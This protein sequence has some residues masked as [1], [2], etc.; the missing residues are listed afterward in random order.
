LNGLVEPLVTTLL[1]IE[2]LAFM[3]LQRHVLAQRERAAKQ[4]SL[5]PVNCR[6]SSPT[7]VG[8]NGD[9]F[10]P[11][12]LAKYCVDPAPVIS[13]WR[14]A[15]RPG[16]ELFGRSASPPGGLSIRIGVLKSLIF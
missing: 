10:G 12:T 5:N 16:A 6:Q 15:R 13:S 7:P 11:A 14:E 2:V 1:L 3:A 9:E 4:Q 8:P